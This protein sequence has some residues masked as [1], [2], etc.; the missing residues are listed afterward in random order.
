MKRNSE[1]IMGNRLC[2]SKL[3][4]YVEMSLHLRGNRSLRPQVF[5][6]QL[7]G[8]RFYSHLDM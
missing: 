5:S 3:S 2:F 1:K 7:L 4:K 6:P 8:P